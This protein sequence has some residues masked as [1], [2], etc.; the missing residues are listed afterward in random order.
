MTAIRKSNSRSRSATT[1][2]FR[3]S[4]HHKG[5]QHASIRTQQDA[6]DAAPSQCHARLRLYRARRCGPVRTHRRRKGRSQEIQRPDTDRLRESSQIRERLAQ[7]RH[8]TSASAEI[9]EHET[10]NNTGRIRSGTYTKAPTQALA[11]AAS[12][13]HQHLTPAK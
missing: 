13:D 6:G 7:G 1:R 4:S 11:H 2:S 5:E 8:R 3:Y 12:G 10:G 9:S